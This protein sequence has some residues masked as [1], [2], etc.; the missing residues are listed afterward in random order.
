MKKLSAPDPP[1]I[2]HWRAETLA[3]QAVARR[4]F[5]PSMRNRLDL[6][7]IWRQAGREASA[8]LDSHGERLVP[9]LP[10]KNPTTLDDLISRDF[11]PDATLLGIAQAL[12][13]V[14]TIKP[15]N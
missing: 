1:S 6:D 4:Q 11:E 3:F 15:I 5:S 2:R 7:D 14:E 10:D 9:G 12:A 8:Q 13:D